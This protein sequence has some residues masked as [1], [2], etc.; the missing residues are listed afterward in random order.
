[1]NGAFW[2][3]GFYGENPADISNSLDP[4]DRELDPDSLYAVM[5]TFEGDWCIMR[6]D[7]WSKVP[8]KREEPAVSSRDWVSTL[9]RSHYLRYLQ[10]IKSEIENGWVYQVNACRLLSTE[11]ELNLERLFALIQDLHPA[12][13]SGYWRCDRWQIAS[14]SP[15]TFFRV[16]SSDG[17]RVITT[18]P[19]KGTSR[20]GTFAKKDSA[21]NVMIVDLMRNDISPLCVGGS[22]T[23]PRLL[24]REEH[25]GLFHLVSDVTGRL[26]ESVKWSE[27][28][29]RMTPAGSISGAPK[30]SALDVIGRWEEFRGP[31]CGTLGWIHNGQAHFSV[32]IRSFYKDL[33]NGPD[34]TYFGTGAGITWGSDA[35]LEWQETVLK[36]ERL[37]Q[38]ADMA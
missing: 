31:Y 23:V 21:E 12:P 29:Q 8:F 28:L 25:P 7:R 30:S 27:I 11:S 24:E 22:V 16:E 36:A 34:L 19:I 13:A 5:G 3:D 1:M 33:V 15:E 37:M 35:E 18:S 14:A 2:M 10:E 32:L 26:R 38:I 17:E 9:T 20:D 4:L 6:F